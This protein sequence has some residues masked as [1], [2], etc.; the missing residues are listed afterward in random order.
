[1]FANV[2]KQWENAYNSGNSKDFCNSNCLS[3]KIL[4]GV[5]KIKDQLTEKLEKL[6]L[7]SKKK[8]ENNIHS[9][10]FALVKGVIASALFPLV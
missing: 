5:S 9:T 3:E 1:M 2:V 10:N 7:T 8:K 6:N 4:L